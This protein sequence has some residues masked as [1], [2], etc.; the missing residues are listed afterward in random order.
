MKKKCLLA[1]VMLLAFGLMLAACGGGDSAQTESD[2]AEGDAPQSV[3]SDEV[4]EFIVNLTFGETISPNWVR[5]FKELEENSGGR[6]KVTI[7][8]SNS[9][10]TIPEIPKSMMS[11]AVTFSNVPTNNYPDIMPLN[12]RLLELP[13]LGLQ[14]PV[15]S[16]EIYMQLLDEFPEM[17]DEFA[18]YDMYPLAVTTLG[19]YGLHF[20]DTKEVHLPSDLN[21]R[22]IVPYKLEFLPMLEA[23]NAAGSYIPPGQIYEALE[24]GVVNGYVNN[25]AFQGWFGLTELVR[26]HVEMGEYGAFHE[27][28][29]LCVNLS[30]LDSLPE[31][32]RQLLVDTFRT[33]GGYRDMWD[34][35][36][37][38]VA[39]E[40]EK[41]RAKGDVFVNLT[42]DEIDVWKKAVEG[43]HEVALAEI[44]EQR[45]DTAADDIYARIVEIIEEKYGPQE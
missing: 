34:D 19:M 7:Y 38:L 1:V 9:L 29:V 41:A 14:D 23:N 39:N 17:M 24:K 4:Y 2:G 18:A 20:T 30:F 32:L 27:F 22:Q 6:L 33:N 28:N 36:A 15:E 35:T 45:G 16:S 21:G 8:W 26:Q 42:P 3:A 40:Q 31:D 12:A 25:W 13:F 5:I 43:N 11:G 10:V 37:A 44:N